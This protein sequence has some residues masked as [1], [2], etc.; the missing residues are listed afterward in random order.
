MGREEKSSLCYL[1]K[2]KKSFGGEKRNVGFP[3]RPKK[4]GDGNAVFRVLTDGKKEKKK[5]NAVIIF[6]TGRKEG[7][8]GKTLRYPLH[9]NKGGEGKKKRL[10]ELHNNRE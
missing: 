3:V 4:E 2:K 7:G 10:D 1:E 6:F 9:L 5:D 8:T